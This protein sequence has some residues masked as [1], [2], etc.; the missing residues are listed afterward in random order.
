MTARPRPVGK[1][2]EPRGIREPPRQQPAQRLA[3]CLPVDEGSWQDPEECEFV[4]EHAN[5]VVVRGQALPVPALDAYARHGV[6]IEQPPR[7]Q[8]FE[9]FRLLADSVREQVLATPQE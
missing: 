9:L 4:A 1:V 8:V 2:R 5:E 3:L 6:A 7:V